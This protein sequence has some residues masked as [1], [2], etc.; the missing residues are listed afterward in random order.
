MYK[1]RYYYSVYIWEVW[2]KG[3]KL[4]QTGEL[5]SYF[6]T[7]KWSF[8]CWVAAQTSSN[9]MAVNEWIYRS[10][11]EIKTFPFLILH[12]FIKKL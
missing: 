6:N 4:H 8:D 3:S 1:I 11:D 10:Y 5:P 7:I 2:V 12:F 9:W